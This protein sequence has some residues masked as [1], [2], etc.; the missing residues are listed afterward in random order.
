VADAIL[1]LLKN[2][3]GLILGIC[4]G[5]QA[6]IKTGL[7]PYGEIRESTTDAPTLIHN[8]IGRH[9]S[10]Y[11]HT[12]V[13]STLSPWLSS[14]QVGDIHTIPL[15]HGEGR[16]FAS[17]EIITR[18]AASGQ[19]ATQYCDEN[20]VPSMDIAHNPNGSLGAIE[21]ISSPCGRVFGKMG[22]TERA[23][24]H[25]AKNIPGN[26]HQP[27]FKAGVGYFNT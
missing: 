14:S 6:L 16:F 3:D 20:G 1:D 7:V 13:T 9:L 4:N 24:S 10:R 27:L 11:A 5:F 18:L 25:V 19:I 21:G 12:R 26:K 23:G 8:T 2:R 22:H 15:S 17:P